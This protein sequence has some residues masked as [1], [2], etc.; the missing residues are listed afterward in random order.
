MNGPLRI[1][2]ALIFRNFIVRPAC[3]KDCAGVEEL[4]CSLDM[5]ENLLR[6]LK[7][8]NK[9]RRDDVSH[10]AIRI[11]GPSGTNQAF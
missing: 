5:N 1:C 4:V 9:A 2:N 7:Q 3:S 8:F 10:F 11:K 6:D